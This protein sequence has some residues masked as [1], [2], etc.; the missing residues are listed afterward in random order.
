M[1]GW[2]VDSLVSGSNGQWGLTHDNYGRLFFSR[3]GGENAGSGFQINPAYGQ[4]E[5]SDAY[6]DS[7]FSA[8]W[9]IIK[10]PD[11][12]GGLKRLRA[13]TTLNHFT[14]GNGQSI[15]RGDHLPASLVGD[16][17]INEPVARIIR[18]AKVI[19]KD[20]KVTLANAY[21]QEEF[22]ASSDMNFRPVNTYT[23]PDGC[24]YIVDMNR[25]IIQ[26]GEW[27]KADSYLRPQ[28]QRLSLDKNKQFGRIYRLLYD[29]MQRGPKP[30]MLDEPASK[31]VTYLNHLNGW[32]RDNAQKEIVLRGDKSVVPA[33]KQIA[34]GEQG[35]L[36]EKPSALGRLHALWTLDGL[37]AT[38]KEVILK[39]MEDEDAQ[40]RKAA[41]WISE[42]F[43][44]KNDEQVIDK[45]EK[46]KGDESYEVRTQLM[47]SLNYAK[48]DKAKD[49]VK[50]ILEKNPNNEMLAA[51]QTSL[52]R[53]EEIK[54]F[55][56]KLGSLNVANRKMLLEG[57]NIFRSLCASCHGSDGKGLASKIAPPLVGNFR[58]LI[59]Q[60]D[61][62]I[63]ILLHGLTGPV[64]GKTYPVDMPSMGSNNDQWIASVLSYLRYD[65]GITN[66]SG[67]MSPEFLSRIMVKPDEVK[68][69]RAQTVVRNKPWTMAE[70]E[71]AGK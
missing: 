50:N 29:G 41:V 12:Q 71:K 4:L 56:M 31:L 42:S 65:L 3:G 62:T 48:A 20:G 30:Q 59:G 66:R 17:L 45:L 52:A 22:I 67:P 43:I 16:Y 9:P 24:L 64:N 54:K 25:G 6:D 49:I 55:G 2:E 44:K 69:I 28:I 34:L 57:A 37:E 32:W 40:V 19:N 60:K 70:L 36:K 47:L 39:A 46:L 5:F 18:R 63:M 7:T 33:L 23:G 13:D 14:A 58:R 21:K 53:N 1:A 8:V 11:V 27:T 68:K 35:S 61:T 15:F 51:V 38:D 10:T 26:E